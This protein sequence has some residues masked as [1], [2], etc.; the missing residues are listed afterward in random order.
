MD[1]NMPACFVMRVSLIKGLGSGEVDP[2]RAVEWGSM[3]F[4]YSVIHAKL[5]LLAGD[6]CTTMMG[7]SELGPVY[8]FDYWKVLL[9]AQALR[10]NQAGHRAPR[11]LLP[12]ERICTPNERIC[13][14]NTSMEVSTKILLSCNSLSATE[15]LMVHA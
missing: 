10:E 12:H 1:D 14:P 15:K 9:H 5:L 4:A 7:A 6:S 8:C 2:F 3:V 11:R 13:T